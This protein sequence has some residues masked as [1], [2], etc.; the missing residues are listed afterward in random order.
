MTENAVGAEVE[1]VQSGNAGQ[2]QEEV[3]D[4]CLMLVEEQNV[5]KRLRLDGNIIR[6]T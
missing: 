1:R 6:S 4:Q 5:L 2:P 3:E